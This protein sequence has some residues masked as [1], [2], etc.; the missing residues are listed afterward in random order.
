[1]AVE[2]GTQQHQRT[3]LI[4]DDEASVRLVL[5]RLLAHIGYDVLEADD[6]AR[7]LE[8]VQSRPAPIDCVLLDIAMPGMDGV[9]AARALHSAQ[10]RLPLVLMSGHSP[11]WVASRQV[12]VPVCGFLQKPFSFEEIERTLGAATHGEPRPAA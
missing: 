6:G 5:A 7:A 1:M 10:P 3:V 8:V 12:D 11:G 4:V 9:E 2:R